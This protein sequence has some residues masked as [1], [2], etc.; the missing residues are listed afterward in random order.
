MKNKWNSILL[1]FSIAVLSACKFNVTSDLYTSDLRDAVA[2]QNANLMALATLEIEVVSDEQCKE[3]AT[4]IADLL[5]GFV[6]KISTRG[7][8]SKEFDTYLVLDAKI[9]IVNGFNSWNRANSL[10]GIVAVK[11][12]MGV[13]VFFASDPVKFQILNKRV[14]DEFD[15]SL[16]LAESEVK[17][18]L[19]GDK[20]TETVAVSGAFVNGRPIDRYTEFEL[21]RRGKLEILLSNVGSAHIESAGYAYAFMLKN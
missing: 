4:E 8:V 7:C 5:E 17:L 14:S 3:N 18:N 6:S 12:K 11:S 13:G 16:N 15:Q 2:N 1:I 10:L 20:Q 9:P 21:A 19:R